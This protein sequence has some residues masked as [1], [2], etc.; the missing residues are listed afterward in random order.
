MKLKFFWI[1]AAAAAALAIA[2][3]GGGDGPSPQ[4]QLGGEVA[5]VSQWTVVMEGQQG[6]GE[7]RS[8]H[9]LWDADQLVT[10]APPAQNQTAVTAEEIARLSEF[11][12]VLV[13]PGGLGVSAGVRNANT[14]VLNRFRHAFEDALYIL[15]APW[16]ERRHY[17]DA[18]NALRDAWDAVE[19][20]DNLG[21]N[22][23]GLQ[24][25]ALLAAIHDAE[26]ERDMTAQSVVFTR[27]FA[28]GTA[29]AAAVAAPAAFAA[30]ASIGGFADGDIGIEE[31]SLPGSLP[32]ANR[33]FRTHA[34]HF[35]NLQS[36]IVDARVTAYNTRREGVQLNQA[37]IN[38][39]T[40]T[41]RER[42]V[43]IRNGREP[44]GPIMN[45]AVASIA[46]GAAPILHPTFVAL[47]NG[48]LM[49]N[50]SEITV[51][52]P[53][54]AQ[55][56][57]LAIA[58]MAGQRFPG[59]TGGTGAAGALTPNP[60]FIRWELVD[61]AGERLSAPLPRGV[62]L[63]SPTLT[64]VAIGIDHTAVGQ[65]L[66]V[67]QVL[68]SHNVAGPAWAAT[69][70]NVPGSAPPAQPTVTHPSNVFTITVV[71]PAPPAP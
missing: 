20:V 6:V 11:R 28:S 5:R 46:G 45:V 50:P 66:R 71:A 7:W 52:R 56:A 8:Y 18:R 3:G 60:E 70:P 41:V 12:D 40:N 58:L 9:D 44:D 42:T 62:T 64:G 24:R 65:T 2:C 63:S 36:V 43:A 23:G 15:N 69:L 30:S 47:D 57:P 61:E 54:D 33:E 29:P 26:V 67:R 68:Y 38:A 22:P 39:M 25:L 1:G 4:Q 21:R 34:T 59:A 17:V 14:A 37:H 51:R 27:G 49:I 10:P 55:G 16:A 35:N 19:A 32:Q 31:A 13:L 48:G 53:V